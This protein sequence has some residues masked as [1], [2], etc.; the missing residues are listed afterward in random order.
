MFALR[1]HQCQTGRRSECFSD[2]TTNDNR[3]LACAARQ[4]DF[5]QKWILQRLL[6]SMRSPPGSFLIGWSPEP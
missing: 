2:V 1:T 4:A 5:T 3:P 6:K